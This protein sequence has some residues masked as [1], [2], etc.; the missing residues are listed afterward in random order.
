MRFVA[1][2]CSLAA[3]LSCG[4][5]LCAEFGGPAAAPSGEFRG[6]WVTA[7]EPGFFTPE[8]VDATVAAAK[9]GRLTALFIQVRK[10]GDAY[11]KSATEPRGNAIADGFDPLAYV[12]QRAHEQ[13]IQVHAWVNTLRMWS[14]KTPP[15]DPRH[16]ANRHP[17]WVIKDRDGAARATEGLYL[18]PGIPEA[19]EYIASVIEEIARNYDVDGIHLDYIRYPGREWG[20]STP[21]L[22]AYCLALGKGGCPEPGDPKWLQ[23]KRDQ[24]T[25]L[26]RLVR[27][28]VKAVK[29]NVLLSASTVPWGDCPREFAAGTP[30]ALLCQDWRK[31]AV[32]G[33]IDAN[34][35]MNYKDE[36]NAKTARQFRNWLVGFSRWSGGKPVY[37][38]I[39]VHVN[40]IAQVMRQIEAVRKAKLDGFV[41]FA[42]N[43]TNRR[44][45]LVNA[46]KAEGVQAARAGH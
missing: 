24:V 36:G 16:I 32:E 4:I 39:G 23:W 3:A 18:D 28:K 14:A 5:G 29:P 42:F 7:W 19:R 6:A 21:A 34:C 30:Y 13:G 20:Y 15:L 45:A 9:K 25:E 37:V 26:V 43:Q 40:Q 1:V 11:Y 41:L 35:P 44:D 38:G 17:E 46:L 10:N 2:A 31:W 8:E 33:L 22:K 12:I 27:R